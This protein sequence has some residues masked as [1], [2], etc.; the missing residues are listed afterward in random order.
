MTVVYHG[1]AE[2]G[3]VAAARNRVAIIRGRSDSGAM[4][5]QPERAHGP[6]MGNG[7][8]VDH[9]TRAPGTRCCSR[10]H[11]SKRGVAGARNRLMN[12]RGRSDSGAMVVEPERAHG[13]GIG[14]G[15]VVDH[16]ICA[17][18]TRCTGGF[19]WNGEMA[20]P[21]VERASSLTSAGEPRMSRMGTDRSDRFEDLPHGVAE[22]CD[23]IGQKLVVRRPL[24]AILARSPLTPESG[25]SRRSFHPC[26]SGSIRGELKPLDGSAFRIQGGGR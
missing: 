21:S 22:R 19:L 15:P 12:I 2:T 18:G 24:F 1:G 23:R 11:G 3:R 17:P 20:L 16:R 10:R 26:P 14:N 6:G 9:V 13:P 8:I 7:P 5:V 4:V 25:H